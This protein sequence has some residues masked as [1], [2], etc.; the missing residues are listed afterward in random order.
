MPRDRRGQ[1][2][3]VAA[4]GLALAFV[5]LA[6]VLNTVVF[7]ENLATRNHDRADDAIGF[8]NAVEDGV[9]G[10]VV[11][12]NRHDDASNES[13]ADALRDG[14]AAWDENATALSA[15]NGRVTSVD[16]V[17]LDNGTRIVQADRDSAIEDADGESDWLVAGDVS[18]V[19]RFELVVTPT[20][21]TTPLNLSLAGNDASWRIEVVGD[22]AGGSDVTAF[23]N[24]TPVGT[25]NEPNS[26]VAVDVTEGTVNG[27]S[28]ANWT[29]AE[30]VST[31]YDVNVR[32]GSSAE[33]QYV[34]VVD[35]PESSLDTE[36]PD[37]RT[38]PAIYSADVAVTVRESSLTYQTNVTV[39]PEDGIGTGE[40]VA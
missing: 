24:G 19:R 14:V 25:A 26:T 35:E 6:L 36:A 34:L 31:P 37:T 21:E 9:G 23:R 30:G 33:G 27:T 12:V 4:L 11:E 16:V 40:F 22:G 2:L 3:L 18:D 32:N 10:L 29:F 5:A 17:S 15:A 38:R 1:L 28:V 8:Q 20:S 7:T 39:P 13:L